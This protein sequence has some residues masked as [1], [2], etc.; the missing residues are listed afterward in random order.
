MVTF[1]IE[2]HFEP[3]KTAK[4]ILKI[5]SKCDNH[6]GINNFTGGCHVPIIQGV[7]KNCGF[8]EKQPQLPYLLPDGH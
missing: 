2:C 7:P 6:S 8:V 3:K 5:I 1:S 4:W